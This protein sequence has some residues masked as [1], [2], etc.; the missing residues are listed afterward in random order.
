MSLQ[1][2]AAAAAAAAPVPLPRPWLILLST[3]VADNKKIYQ[4]TISNNNVTNKNNNNKLELAIN[5][6][7]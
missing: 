6:L 7:L 5:D 3:L 1:P 4:L 2:N